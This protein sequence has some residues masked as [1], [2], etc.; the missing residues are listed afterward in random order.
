[1]EVRKGAGNGGVGCVCFSEQC[2]LRCDND[3]CHCTV[4]RWRRT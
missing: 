3:M 1:M 4:N 2:V